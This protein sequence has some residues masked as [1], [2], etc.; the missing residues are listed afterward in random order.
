LYKVYED[1]T[2]KK[3]IQF[4]E[5]LR[6]MMHSAGFKAAFRQHSKDFSR[7]RVFTFVGLLTSQINRMSKSLSVEVSRFVERFFGSDLDYSKQAYSR[8]RSKLKYEAYTALN[9]QFISSYYKNGEYG[10]WQGYL[11]LAGDSST[12]QLPLSQELAAAFGTVDNKGWS[13][14]MA[15]LSLI[16]DVENRLV[17]ESLL[18][19]YVSSEKNMLEEQLDQLA[20]LE[21]PAACLLL[22]R[23]YPSLWLIACLQKRKTG[24]LMRCSADFITEVSAFAH[25]SKQEA[26][27]ELD[28][29]IGRR[30]EQ[31]RL[32]AY[33]APGQTMLSVRAA[34]VV[35]L[36][37]TEYLLTSLPHGIPLLKELYHKRWGVESRLDFM[38]NVLEVENFSAKTELGIRQ[39]FH[40]AVLCANISAILVEEAQQELDQQQQGKANK[41]R[42]QINRSVALGLVKDNLAELLMG[43]EPLDAL[44]DKLKNKIK[45]RK[46]AIK[47]GRKFKRKRHQGHKFKTNRRKVI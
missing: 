26:I 3:G 5:E 46:E 17:L 41:H 6:E 44:Y 21:L 13:M 2:K 37:G 30:L 28:L 47:P 22:D 19:G 8:C 36:T 31:E 12:L 20:T 40:A 38:K 34:K 43:T 39:E 16:Y 29:K 24:F 9:R 14:P 10:R 45:R 1:V 23:G 33:L 27:L 32:Q 15:R 42:Y 7:N 4:L 25:S 11:L 35:L 18:A